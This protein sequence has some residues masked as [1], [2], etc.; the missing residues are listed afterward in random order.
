M[1]ATFG[2]SEGPG[3]GAS[4]GAI[5]QLTKALAAAYAGDNIRVN[6]VAP[7][8]IDTPLLAPFK[9]VPEV[10]DPILART[11]F[12]RFGRPVEIASVIAFLCSDEAT[13]V[14]G[15]TLNVDGGYT[16]G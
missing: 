8:W 12:H 14:T 16:V 9:N 1:F 5:D 15:Q 4:K 11:P 2:D 3:Y 7:G 10:A 13:W 6:A